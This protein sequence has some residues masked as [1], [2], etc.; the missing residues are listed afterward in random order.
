[1]QPHVF[2]SLSDVINPNRKRADSVN[3]GTSHSRYRVS[4]IVSPGVGCSRRNANKQGSLHV[5]YKAR[6][7]FWWS[8]FLYM[9]CYL[10]G[11]TCKATAYNL[12]CV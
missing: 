9:L 7:L 3:M 5:M 8:V 10:L 6:H 11:R 4:S 2:L 1:M 12:L